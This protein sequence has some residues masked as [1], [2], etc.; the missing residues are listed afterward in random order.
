[1]KPSV[2]PGFA[3]LLVLILVATGVILGM[4]YLSVASLRVN[5][6]G[7]LQSMARARYLAESGL[8]H[9]KY[10]LRLDPDALD[11]GAELGP[12]Y[13]DDSGDGYT[14]SAAPL[15]G[16]PGV[17]VLS[18][19]AVV[20][21]V[22]RI[23]AMKVYRIAGSEIQVNRGMLVGG[24]AVWL[25]WRLTLT[26]DVHV[27][28]FLFNNALID[29]NASATS[30]LTD[31]WGRI[32]GTTDGEAEAVEMPEITLA[33]Y[34]NYRIDGTKY[35]ATKFKKQDLNHNDPLAD[36]GAIKSDNPGGVVHLK[37]KQGQ[38]VRLNH[39]LDF[40][41]TLIIEGDIQLAGANIRLSSVEG[42]PTI[43]ASGRVLL[44]SAARNVE[45]N[46]LVVAGQGILRDGRTTGSS[47]TIN[48][49]L[50]SDS[51][52]YGPLLEGTHRLNYRKDLATI[53]DFS[54]PWKQ[55]TPQVSVLVWND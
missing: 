39:D 22:R 18:G 10:T 43:V 54:V 30:G 15:A 55:R 40:T 35:K 1:M 24:G 7:N 52:G 38:M 31:V 14:F 47:T 23:S 5:M 46:G 12:F 8:E 51:V 20:G 6:S 13:A 45:I 33:Q 21:D 9:A 32:S 36:G 34:K 42:F 19:G 50:V 16:E 25:P 49:A 29:G 17:Y 28:G 37:P 27:N 48:G 3:M 26:G 2:R 44:T 41:G 4:S 11:S 53:H